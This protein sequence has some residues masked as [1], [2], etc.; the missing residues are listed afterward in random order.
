M[1]VVF[2]G[3]ARADLRSIGAYVAAD[4]PARANT[5]VDELVDACNALAEMP[6]IFPLVP[7]YE[8]RGVRR[9]GHGRYLI[10]YR[11]NEERGE[12]LHILHGAQDYERLLFPEI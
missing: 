5:F 1:R 3:P 12:I 11:I 10:F 2:T 4:N 8:D 9:R 7:R 6:R